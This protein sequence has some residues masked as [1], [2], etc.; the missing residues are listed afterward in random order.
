MDF[1]Y[2]YD[3]NYFLC[4]CDFLSQ[5]RKSVKKVDGWSLDGGGLK[6]DF[7]NMHLAERDINKNLRNSK[8]ARSESE[9]FPC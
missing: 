9:C 3:L 8:A 7:K 4:S 6:N 1:F 5:I 2:L